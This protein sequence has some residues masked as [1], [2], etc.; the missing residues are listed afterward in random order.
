M[1]GKRRIDDSA[2]SNC[3]PPW[4]DTIIASAPKSAAR[5]A[6]SSSNTPFKINL[7]PHI[8]RMRAILPQ[9]SCGSNCSAFHDPNEDKSLTPLAWPTMLPKLCRLVRAMPAAQRHLVAMSMI[10]AI[11]GLGGAERPFFKSLCLWPMICKS[12]VRTKAEQFALRARSRALATK[13]QSF[14]T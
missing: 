8:S 14:I 2:P 13:S 1:L 11:V 3:R 7:P 4:F 9:S 12:S 6:S 10:L 5:R